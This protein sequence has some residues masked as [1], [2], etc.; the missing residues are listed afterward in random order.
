MSDTGG[1]KADVFVKLKNS[2]VSD[3]TVT[4]LPSPIVSRIYTSPGTWNE[5]AFKLNAA[6]VVRQL[7]EVTRQSPYLAAVIVFFIS[8]SG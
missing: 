2:L 1:P 3:P 7:M 8:P 6:E 4:C 5:E